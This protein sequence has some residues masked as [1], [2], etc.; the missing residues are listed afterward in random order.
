MQRE[1]PPVTK[2]VNMVQHPSALQLTWKQCSVNVSAYRASMPVHP[3]DGASCAA[4][5]CSECLEMWKHRL[6]S[7]C[8]MHAARHMV[9][10]ARLPDA[11]STG[12]TAD[13]DAAT[14]WK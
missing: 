8:H 6:S 9:Y 11:H 3:G 1:H 10:A 12:T 2:P 5:A 4:I 13:V 14:S 7:S